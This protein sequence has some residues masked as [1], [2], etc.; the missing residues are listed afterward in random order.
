MEKYANTC[1]DIV[2]TAHARDFVNQGE[3]IGI[4][5]NKESAFLFYFKNIEK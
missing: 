4:I 2:T 1:N 3:S 5:I